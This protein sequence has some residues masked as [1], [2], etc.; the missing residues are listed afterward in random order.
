MSNCPCYRRTAVVLAVVFITTSLSVSAQPTVNYGN[1]VDAITTGSGEES[2]PTLPRP[3]SVLRGKAANEM[4]GDSEI[5]DAMA[6]LNPKTG[7]RNSFR[8]RIA[9]LEKKKAIW[10]LQITLCHPDSSVQIAALRALANLKDPRAVHFLLIYSE[11]MAVLVMGS[12]D[13]TIHG[14]IHETLSRTLSEITGVTIP[15][16]G[17]DPESLKRAIPLWE[18][19]DIEH[20]TR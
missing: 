2:Y 5:T 17:Q 11:H 13:A 12:E 6:G 18:K 8:A 15:I 3:S 4:S 9:A 1:V 16:H 19:W 10:C 20:A 7:N 14:I